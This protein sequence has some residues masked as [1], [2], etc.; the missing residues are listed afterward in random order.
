MPLFVTDTLEQLRNR[1]AVVYDD[2]QVFNAHADINYQMKEDIRFTIG[3]DYY[4]YTPSSQVAVWYHPTLK[5]SLLGEYAIS[6]DT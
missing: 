3:G 2:V 4:N 1:F 6:D 5:L